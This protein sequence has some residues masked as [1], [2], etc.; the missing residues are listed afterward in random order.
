[1]ISTITFHHGIRTCLACV[2]RG[3]SGFGTRPVCK[4]FDQT[5]YAAGNIDFGRCSQCIEKF[6]EKE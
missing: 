6:G 2:W 4:L 1:M 3:M 5:L